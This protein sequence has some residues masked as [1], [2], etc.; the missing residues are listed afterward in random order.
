MISFGNIGVI[1]LLSVGCTETGGSDAVRPTPT[2]SN[3]GAGAEVDLADGPDRLEVVG[4]T[5]IMRLGPEVLGQAPGQAVRGVLTW[6]DGCVALE[7]S[8]ELFNLLLP[9]TTLVAGSEPNLTLTDD[10]SGAAFKIGEEIFASGL[11]GD[12]AA[13]YVESQR[14]ANALDEESCSAPYA[15]IPD[16]SYA[17]VGLPDDIE[18][19]GG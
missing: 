16:W 11:S 1:A 15:A 3:T 13:A 18:E 19:S 2:S 9:A 8:G 12:E 17:Q 5:T 10:V 4:S 14:S 6:N 7:R